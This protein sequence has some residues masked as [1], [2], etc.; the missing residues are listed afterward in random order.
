MKPPLWVRVSIAVAAGALAAALLWL[1]F[2]AGGGYL[3]ALDF[4]SYWRGSD[5]FRRGISPYV[6]VNAFSKQY[7]FGAG[8]LNMMP[9]AVLFLPLAYLAPQIAAV[10]AEGVSVA[11]FAFALTRDGYWRL[12]LLASYPLIFC[13]LSAQV[14]PLVTAA[15]LLPALGFLAP[16]K[17]TLG[18][19]GY[20]YNLSRRYAVLAIAAVCITVV[21][22]PW[23]PAQW[24][25]ERHDVAGTYYHVPLLLPG[26]FLALTALWRWRRPEARLVAAMAC[27]PQTMLYYDQ[28]PLG[29]VAKSYRECLA[30]AVLSWTAPLVAIA[31][32]GNA[33][34]DREVLFRQN[35]PIILALYYL[36]ALFLVLIRN[37]GVTA[38]QSVNGAHRL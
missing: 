8:Y 11:T 37:K 31:L 21:I 22:W 14:V 26:G 2:R 3:Y 38:S 7:P 24:W 33:A 9:A 19:V 30:A 4:S 18:A 20:A 34:T 6:A 13:V 12:P 23:W 29:L 10:V 25:A 5:A 16:V 15:M 17:F 35:G 27:V 32:H 28:L 1:K 36:P